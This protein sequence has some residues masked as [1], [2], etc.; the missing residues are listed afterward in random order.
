MVHQF[1]LLLFHLK[2]P[3]QHG[4][5]VGYKRNNLEDIRCELNN[6]NN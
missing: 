1:P 5:A 4:A 3:H 2:P 6:S